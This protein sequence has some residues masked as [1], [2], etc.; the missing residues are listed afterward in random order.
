MMDDVSKQSV[1]HDYDSM[2]CDELE[3]EG[4]FAHRPRAL[5]K[6]IA[7]VVDVFQAAVDSS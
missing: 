1:E 4:D 5:N 2:G 7:G 3:R 6:P